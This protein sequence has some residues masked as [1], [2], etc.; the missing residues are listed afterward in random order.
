MFNIADGVDGSPISYAISYIINSHSDFRFYN[1]V[2]SVTES[3]VNGTCEYEGQ[4]SPSISLLSSDNIT[5]TV[6]GIKIMKNNWLA[7]LD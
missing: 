5:V 7:K 3:C 2:I 1:E 4:V 6:S